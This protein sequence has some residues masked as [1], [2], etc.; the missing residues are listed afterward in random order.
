MQTKRDIQDLLSSAGV[1]PNRRLGQ[2]FLVDLNVMRLLVDSAGIRPADVVLEIGAGTGS[3]TEA[4][5]ERAGQVVSVELD[6]TLAAIAGA[7]LA[8]VAN[9]RLLH[10]DA[11]SGKGAVHPAVIEAVA[12]ARQSLSRA[13]LT[14]PIA[15]AGLVTGPIAD[16]AVRGRLLLVSNLPYDVACP[17][18]VNLVKGPLT[19]DAMFVTV[20]KEVADRMAASPGMREYGSLSIFLGATGMVKTVRILKPGIFWP[21]PQVDSAI[22]RHVRDEASCRRIADMTLFGEVVGLFLG[23]RRKMLRACV[24]HAGPEL[25]DRAIWQRIFEQCEI[26]PTRRPEELSPG[27][28]V[29]LANAAY[30]HA[31]RR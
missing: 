22:V 17:V 12:Q 4:L 23:H 29:A 15:P 7:R 13:G 25:A 11:L 27:Q 6:P 21:P 31:A 18:M 8:G 30:E 16:S 20:Q 10:T 28:Y 14:G 2:H 5:A 1:S 9:V 3:L 24:K 26:D 19:A